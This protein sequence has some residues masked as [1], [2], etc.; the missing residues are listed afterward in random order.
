M[1]IEDEAHPGL[2]K[3]EFVV[4][5][6]GDGHIFYVPINVACLSGTVRNMLKGPGQFREASSI[7]QVELEK[8]RPSAKLE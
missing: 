3:E 2:E 4:L 8:S 5:G 7:I 1:S 6:T